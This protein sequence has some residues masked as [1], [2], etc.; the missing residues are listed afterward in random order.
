MQIQLNTKIT[1]CRNFNEV[2]SGIVRREGVGGE[3]KKPNQRT[4]PMNLTQYHNIL[5]EGKNEF[6]NRV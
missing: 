5:P 2:K 6:F 3:S 1:L 4:N